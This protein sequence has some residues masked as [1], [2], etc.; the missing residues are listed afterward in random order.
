VAGGA[1]LY[2]L[3]N[4][5]GKERKDLS[6]IKTAQCLLILQRQ[7]LPGVTHHACIW[8]QLA[9]FSVLEPSANFLVGRWSV[10]GR[11]QQ[12]VYIICIR[13]SSCI[14]FNL[15]SFWNE[16]QA[17]YAL[18]IS[19]LAGIYEYNAC[20]NMRNWI[21]QVFQTVPNLRWHILWL[22]CQSRAVAVKFVCRRAA[23]ATN[24][25]GRKLHRHKSVPREML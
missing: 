8:K 18:Y 20:R 19:L 24:W 7:A 5:G 6:L 21:K 10:W 11:Q 2:I 22:C 15:F 17:S 14:S 9:S 23:R 13:A 12:C 16:L 4:E 3:M 1:G 25:S